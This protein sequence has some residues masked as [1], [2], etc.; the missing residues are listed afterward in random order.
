MVGATGRDEQ[1]IRAL[2]PVKLEETFIYRQDAVC[3]STS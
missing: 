2:R 1:L 3:V